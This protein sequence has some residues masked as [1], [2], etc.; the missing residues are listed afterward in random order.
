MRYV[1]GVI[2]PVC[3]IRT[4]AFP[5]GSNDDIF[6][7]NIEQKSGSLNAKILWFSL[8]HLRVSM[9]FRYD[10][11]NSFDL[12]SIPLVGRKIFILS[13]A[14]YFFAMLNKPVRLSI[15]NVAF[16]PIKTIVGFISCSW[17]N[18]N[19]SNAHSNALEFPLNLLC[20]SGLQKSKDT[21]TSSIELAAISKN[22]LCV[23][24]WWLR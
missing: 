2:S 7:V 12:S 20:C 5:D 23:S 9:I 10:A 13:L 17:H 18:S 3:K 4:L 15:F 11:M 14:L 6:S 22:L 1:D 24:I 16:V 19:I 8:I 21:S